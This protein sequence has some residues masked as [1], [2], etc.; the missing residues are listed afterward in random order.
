[1]QKTTK[2]IPVVCALIERDG[3]L[4]AAQR[5]AGKHGALKWEFPGGKVH[6][7]EAPET[8]LI[9]EIREELGAEIILR[10]KLPPHTHDYENMRI[11]LIP[12]LA[13]LSKNSPEP[14]PLEHA[15]LL[16][17]SP[18]KLPTLDWTAADIPIIDILREEQKAKHK[19]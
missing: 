1:M 11:Q 18:D 12:F 4:L 9:R 15:A 17:L 19:E 5:P 6:E 16:W 7:N 13:R 10:D 8:A 14:R 3:L 2:T